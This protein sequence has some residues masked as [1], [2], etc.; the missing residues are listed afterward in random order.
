MR[1][2]TPRLQRGAVSRARETTA[3]KIAR[4]EKRASLAA[5]VQT[6]YN[7]SSAVED[8]RYKRT[9]RQKTT[10]VL[11]LVDKTEKENN[12]LAFNV[13]D[14]DFSCRRRTPTSPTCQ[15]TSD[16]CL[17]GSLAT[18]S[19]RLY[20]RLRRR[21]LGISQTWPEPKAAFTNTSVAAEV[22]PSDIRQPRTEYAESGCS[23]SF[24]EIQVT[25]PRTT[26]V[27][28]DGNK[29]RRAQSRGNKT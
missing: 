29:F 26:A 13:P 16:F 15:A 2:H 3:F 20:C 18:L 12:F 6:L 5:P 24:P 4:R 10:F 9:G 17:P 25:K 28:T 21:H 19:R 23:R 22:L 27:A 1:P 14:N 8:F 7:E 11:H